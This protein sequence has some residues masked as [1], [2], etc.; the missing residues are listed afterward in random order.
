[1]GD[2]ADLAIEQGMAEDD[3]RFDHPDEFEDENSDCSPVPKRYVPKLKI[4]NQ[5]GKNGF[6]WQKSKETGGWRLYDK[7]NKIHNCNKKFTK[8]G[9]RII[10]K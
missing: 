5:C 4:C 3:Y 6:H 8:G 10:Y 9:K 7:N 1:M 2:G